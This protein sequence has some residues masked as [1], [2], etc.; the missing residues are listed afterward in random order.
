MG[1]EL[2]KDP[3]TQELGDA[4][5]KQDLEKAKQELEKLAE[6]L[7]NKELDREAEGRALQEAR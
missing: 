7:D 3:L 4:L 5:Q 1:K 6:K 2:A